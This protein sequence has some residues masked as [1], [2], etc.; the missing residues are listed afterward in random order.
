MSKHPRKHS[1]KTARRELQRQQLLGSIPVPP[2]Q[3]RDLFDY[4]DHELGSGCDHNLGITTRFL[5]QRNADVATT[6]KWLRSLGGG[7]DCEVL[8][9]VE[10]AVSDAHPK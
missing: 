5:Q 3:L 4:L 10:D 1:L 2:Q 8:S 7:C 9:N 6:I